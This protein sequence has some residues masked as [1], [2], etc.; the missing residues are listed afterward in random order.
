MVDAGYSPNTAKA[1]SKLTNTDGFRIAMEEAG[2]T[3]KRIADVL[4][5]GLEATR[6]VVMGTKSDESFVDI[7][8]DFAIRH[9]YMET[10]IKVAGFVKELDTPAGNTYNTFI[11]QNNLNPNAPEAKELVETT[12]NTL[13]EQMQRGPG[14]AKS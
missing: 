9:K 11:Q 10:A 2:I 8:P 1:P 12:L 3:D 7:Q 14:T 6:A 13:M 5:E 4:N